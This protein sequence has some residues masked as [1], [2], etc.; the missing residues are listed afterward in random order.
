MTRSAGLRI[1]AMV[2]VPLAVLLA[3][4][5]PAQSAVIYGVG[6]A[7]SYGDPGYEGY[8]HYCID[9]EWNTAEMG[10]HAVSFM[11]FLLSLGPCP[12]ACGPNLVLFSSIAGTGVSNDGCALKFRGLYDC[13]EDPH[14]PELGPSIKF[15][16]VDT[17]CDLGESGSAR[18]CFYST[19]GPDATGYFPEVL[20]IKAST[21]TARGDLKGVLPVCVCGS[22]VEGASWS[23][24]KA[25][26]R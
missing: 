3:A 19:F 13:K 11:N 23:T 21:S 25:L 22:P 5:G 12:C 24:V 15:E 6:T 16:L 4:V 10:G 2:A 26:Y 20:G 17:G 14:F 8:W 7:E 9:V 1:C 18:L